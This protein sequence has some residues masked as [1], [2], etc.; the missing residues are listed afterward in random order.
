M[1]ERHKGKIEAT[2]IMKEIKL[3]LTIKMDYEV[4]DDWDEDTI[5]FTM[6]DNYCVGNII[7]Y[8]HEKIEESESKGIC[9]ICAD[10]EVE[11]INV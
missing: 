2:N 8:L 3:K 10:S 4:P 9:F 5:D 11:V 7:H 6:E 1:C